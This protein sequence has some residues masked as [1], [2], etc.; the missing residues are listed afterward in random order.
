MII[1]AARMAIGVAPADVFL[2]D[3]FDREEYDILAD[4]SIRFEEFARTGT[5]NVPLQL[6]SLGNDIWEIKT[7]KARL[8]FYYSDSHAGYKTIRITN[9]FIKRG[10]KCP[11][12][13]I[14]AATRVRGEDRAL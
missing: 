3:L 13:H 14:R 5:L 2:E 1:E 10:Q 4:I 7:P 6:N 8:P 12:R 11:P 9:G